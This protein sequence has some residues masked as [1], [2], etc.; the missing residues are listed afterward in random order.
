M[1]PLE[2][3]QN[4]YKWSNDKNMFTNSTATAQWYKCVSELGELADAIVKD[5]ADGQV[6][7]IGD[8]AVCAAN[9]AYCCGFNAAHV[10][11]SIDNVISEISEELGVLDRIDGVDI[12]YN[13]NIDYKIRRLMHSVRC[14]VISE[15]ECEILFHNL[16][17]VSIAL[18]HDLL[19]CMDHAWNEIKDRKGF[20]SKSGAFIK[21]TAS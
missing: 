14:Q 11:K 10:A 8:I 19:T 4:I 17:C 15:G 12:V 18:G 13:V 6:D 2:F 16:A 3:A 1:T 21:E 7:A 20:F 9:V 5:D